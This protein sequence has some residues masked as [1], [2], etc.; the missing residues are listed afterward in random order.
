MVLR[1]ISPSSS[2]RFQVEHEPRQDLVHDWHH[3]DL[4]PAEKSLLRV[5]AI[6][7]RQHLANLELITS[8]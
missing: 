6:L 8:T 4:L 1:Q 3:Q 5:I 7:A 2:P